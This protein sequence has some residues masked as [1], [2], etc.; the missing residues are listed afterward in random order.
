MYKRS[1]VIPSPHPCSFLHPVPDAH[2][3]DELIIVERTTPFA[4]TRS[5]GSASLRATVTDTEGHLSRFV[6]PLSNRSRTFVMSFRRRRTL[7][8][9]CSKAR[10]YQKHAGLSSAPICH[11]VIEA[12][13]P[14]GR[15]RCVPLLEPGQPGGVQIGEHG[16][17]FVSRAVR[18]LERGGPRRLTRRFVD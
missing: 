17:H 3:F 14:L 12:A 8:F 4:V 9:G 5:K 6:N 11:S 18:D 15:R 1:K 16:R 10:S 2:A 13:W 7:W